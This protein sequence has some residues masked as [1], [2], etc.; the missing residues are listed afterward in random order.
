MRENMRNHIIQHIFINGQ[1]DD[2]FFIFYI[3]PPLFSLRKA[4]HK[5]KENK[6]NTNKY[7]SH[8]S[9]DISKSKTFVSI[10]KDRVVLAHED[11][12]HNPEW[13]TWCWDINASKT[14]QA[15]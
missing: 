1:D 12:T 15:D 3:P 7:N 6:N 2:F 9:F 11:V 5:K 8:L 10:V 4:K 14:K 13:S